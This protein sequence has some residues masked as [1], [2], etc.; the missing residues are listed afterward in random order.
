MNNN[1]KK[2]FFISFVFYH[3][4]IFA[5]GFLLW[6]QNGAGVGDY[7]AGSAVDASDASTEYYNPAGLPYIRNK[8]FVASL[9]P[10]IADVNFNGAIAVSTVNNN[11]AQPLNDEQAGGMSLIPN[12]HYTQPLTPR[13]S[14]GLGMNVPYGLETNYSTETFIRYAA[15]QTSLQTIDIDPTLGYRITDDFSLGGGLDAVYANAIFDQYAGYSLLSNADTLSD[16]RLHSWGWG[17]HVGGLYQITPKSRVGLTYHSKIVEHMKGT[18]KFSGKLAN[19]GTGGTQT[20]NNLSANLYLPPNTTLSGL[21]DVNDQW[22]LLA[23]ATYTQW[24]Y[25]KS[26][27]LQGMAVID[28]QSLDPINNGEVFIQEDFRNTWNVAVGTEYKTS[29]TTT[30]RTGLGY[31]QS[32]VRSPTL[33]YI[34]TPDADRYAL[35]V[36]GQFKPNKKFVF[37]LG[38]THLFIIKAPINSSQTVGVNPENPSPESETV[39]VQGD[40][41]SQADVFGLQFTWNID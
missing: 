30:L 21:Y 20:S 32:P 40:V 12:L 29:L 24:S 27:L 13:L 6:E 1:W 3:S 28:V 26:L 9:V 8:Q 31:D 15:T 22:R 18:S 19:G 14:F 36:G 39:N 35:A 16:N 2:L 25:I 11:T 33:R 38:W 17:Y 4:N 7:H 10:V 23:S 37:D 5:G 41:I 34:Q